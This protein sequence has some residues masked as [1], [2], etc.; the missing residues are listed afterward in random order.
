M[1]TSTKYIEIDSTY[2]NRVLWPKPAEFEVLLSKSGQK[3]AATAEDPVAYGMPKI[4]FTSNAFENDAV[5]SSSVTGSV[6]TSGIGA[7]NSTSIVVFE[8]GN[9]ELHVEENYYRHAVFKSSSSVDRIRIERYEY[10]GNDR[11]KLTISGASSVSLSAGDTIT[12]EDPTDFSNPSFVHVFIPR[13]SNGSSDYSSDVLYN[14]S[15]DEYRKIASYDSNTGTVTIGGVGNTTPV[16]GWLPTHNYSIR[17]AIPSSVIVAAA[18]S[19]TTSIVGVMTSVGHFLRLP[20]SSYGNTVIPP[21]G[22]VRRVTAYEENTMTAT[23]DPPFTADPTGNVVEVLPFSYD[24]FS[25]LVYNGS[26]QSELVAYE[27]KLNSLVVPNQLL[28]TG[29]GDKIVFYPYLYVQLSV[30][31]QATNV[32]YSNNPNSTHALFKASISDVVN[33]TD[34]TFVGLAG[35]GDMV[36]TVRFKTEANF[37]FKVTLPD[38]E[39]FETVEKERF[40]PSRPNPLIQISALFEAKRI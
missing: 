21:Q 11:G 38:G 18:G 16:V 22:E 28:S 14:E 4:S 37:K 29:D 19:T 33:L 17:E 34:S 6:V 27:L 13:G 36:Q 40:S 7:A 39:I 26:K 1:T 31:G 10:L 8:T 35:D 2:R 30:E 3:T 32:M 24:N 5:G 23:V 25:P 12:V 9:D 20:R 15:L